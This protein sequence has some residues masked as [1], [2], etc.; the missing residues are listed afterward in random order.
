MFLRQK[1][2]NISFTDCY[3]QLLPWLYNTTNNINDKTNIYFLFNYFDKSIF[4]QLIFLEIY[5][6]DWIFSWFSNNK[7]KPNI[8]EKSYLQFSRF[9]QLLLLC[10]LT[11]LSYDLKM[12]TGFSFERSQLKMKTKTLDIKILFCFYQ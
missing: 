1:A 8:W 11:F 7:K 10:V 6:C 4:H 5:S 3:T 9:K 12:D 2:L